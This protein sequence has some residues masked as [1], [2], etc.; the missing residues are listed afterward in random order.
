M[1]YGKGMTNMKN[2]K[3]SA[4]ELYV[5]AREAAD[6]PILDDY[7]KSISFLMEQGWSYRRIAQWLTEQGV[8]VTHNQLY[9]AAAPIREAEEKRSVDNAMELDY[10]NN[11]PY[12]NLPE[13]DKARLDAHMIDYKRNREAEQRE[14]EAGLIK[15]ED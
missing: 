6:L 9:Y 8:P 7:L 3:I 10:Y 14:R 4:D 13:E 11:V 12:H 2:Y 5:R 15:D 1:V